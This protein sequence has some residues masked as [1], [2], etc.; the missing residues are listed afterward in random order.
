MDGRMRNA[1]MSGSPHSFP[2]WFSVRGK[3]FARMPGFYDTVA[4]MW[5]EDAYAVSAGSTGNMAWAIL[6]LCEVYENA[7]GNEKHLRAARQIGDFVLTL[8]TANGFAGGYEGWEGNET[9]AAYLSTEHNTD[10]ISAFGRLHK[11]TGEQKYADASSLARSFVLSMYDADNGCFYTG[12]A[13][14]GM[15]VNK[16]V[17]PLDCQTWTLL[18]LGD[19]FADG[20]KVLRYIEENMAVNGGYDFN[21]D[22][23]GVWNEGAAQTAIAYLY[24]GNEVKYYE[25][26]NALNA[27][28]LPDGSI[29]A[30]DRDGVSTG[31]MVSGLDVPWEY[32]ERVHVGATAW[33]AFAQMA[34]NPFEY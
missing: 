26:L 14:D 16:D 11:L 13:N 1:Y 17:V 7:G 22:K 33:L 20:D 10:L 8:K 28:C 24:A 15:A 12:T 6:A 34:R 5:Y 9:K 3:E 32:D 31:F 23:D 19:A 27:R 25:I 21:T 4:E 18:A 2:G 30:A 29:A